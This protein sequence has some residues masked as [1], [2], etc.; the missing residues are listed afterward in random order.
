LKQGFVI[1]DF[2]SQVSQL[3]AR[4][5]RELGYFSEL[6]PYTTPL[7]EIK[8]RAP[9]G[10][11]LS[12]GPSSVFDADAPIAEVRDLLQVAPLFGI[13]YGMQ[14][15]AHVFGGLVEASDKREYG[16]TWVEW[17]SEIKG[18]PKEQKV[19][20]SH[21]DVVK[22]PPPG[23][24]IVAFSKGGHPAAMRGPKIMAVQFHPEVAHTE[25]GTEILLDFCQNMCDAKP[26]WMAHDVLEHT[27]EKI[28][29]DVP[30]N[31]KVL[32]ALSGGVDSTVV[33]K[34]LTQA[35]GAERVFCVFVDN[36]LLRKD[37]FKEVLA[38]YKTLGM[39][40]KGLN[41]RS[42]FIDRLAGVSDPEQ[43]RK[44]IGHTFIDI[45]REEIKKHPEITCLA[46]GTLY[47]DV[48][49]S[50]SPRGASV[51][52]KT[53]HN[54]GGLPKDLGLK[55]IEPLRELFKD[56]VRQL[57]DQLKIPR[58]ILWR[59]PFPGPGLA[60]RVMGA[61]SE[62]SLEILREADHIYIEELKKADLYVH[63]WQAFSVLLPVQTV[64][65]Q[66]DGRTYEKTLALRAVTSSDGMTAD[67][68]QFPPEFLRSVSNRIT[69]EVKGVNRVVYDI[70][71][72][73]PGTI[74]WE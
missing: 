71:S 52:I 64:G 21:G 72:K 60:I 33:G 24:E 43:K 49:E 40:V 17:K 66:G 14:L 53:H 46:Q 19:W 54:V 61:V 1:L 22:V 63:I 6:L 23:F 47:P 59:H 34:L 69:N 3:I 16:N 32:C 31:E 9:K 37:E 50:V 12:G 56:E 51:T 8:L 68:F 57:G 25:K 26:N 62:D 74:E 41:A 70:T 73:P 39:N 65:V 35:L 29:N 28:K 4:R 38:I 67:W 42:A 45:F 11:I 58:N 55:L 48:I 44:I 7:S 30:E 10:I 36:G 5:L 20:M 18:V 13:C 27:L 15:L 2:G